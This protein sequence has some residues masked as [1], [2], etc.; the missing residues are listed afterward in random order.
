MI[1][2]VFIETTQSINGTRYLTS[3]FYSFAHAQELQKMVIEVLK[4]SNILIDQFTNLSTVGPKI[5]NGLNQ[6]LNQRNERPFSWYNSNNS[7][8]P[9]FTSAFGESS[10][11]GWHYIQHQI[12]HRFKFESH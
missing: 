12:Q 7:N 10:S 11:V 2:A 6:T 5:N 4:L 1:R 8:K 9:S 3:N